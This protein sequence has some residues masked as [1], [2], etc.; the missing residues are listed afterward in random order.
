MYSKTQLTTI[1]KECKTKPFGLNQSRGNKWVN[2]LPGTSENFFVLNASITTQSVSPA[3]DG[4]GSRQPG[5]PKRE[6]KS[7]FQACGLKGR[8]NAL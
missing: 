5:R 6:G 4:R 1:F 7:G 2:A 3:E 8:M